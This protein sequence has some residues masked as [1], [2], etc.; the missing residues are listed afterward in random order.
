MI[1]GDAVLCS[2]PKEGIREIYI[3]LLQQN[4][5]LE[6]LSYSIQNQD[7]ILSLQIFDHSFKPENGVQVFSQ[8][9]EK[10]NEIDDILIGRYKAVARVD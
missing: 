10:A 4:Y 8:L 6:G 1:A 5:L 2:L 9:F 3:F 7:I